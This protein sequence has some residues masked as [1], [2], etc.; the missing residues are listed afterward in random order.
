MVSKEWIGRD[1]G[2]TGVAD[3]LCGSSTMPI[4]RIATLAEKAPIG[5]DGESLGAVE[6]VHVHVL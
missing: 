4:R 1:L 3:T 5:I 2:L 6:H